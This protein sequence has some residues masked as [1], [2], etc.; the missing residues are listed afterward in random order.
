MTLHL[1][2]TPWQLNPPSAA[3]IGEQAAFAEAHGYQ[4][5]WLP[6]N[7][8]GEGALPDPLMLLASAATATRTIQLATTS[9]LL[10]LRNPLQAAEQVAVLDQLSDGRVLLG[11][12]RGY[13][14]EM[15]RAFHVPVAEK[16]RIFAWTLDLMQKA[17]AGEAISLDGDPEHAVAVHPRPVQQPHPPIWVAAFG[18]KA[19]AQ[20]GRMGLPYLSSPMES[21]QTLA[22]NYAQHR[23]ASLD[24]G[25]QPASEIPLMRTVFVSRDAAE[26]AALRQRMSDEVDNT[27]LQSGETVDDWTLIGDPAFVSDGIARYQETLG[28]THLVVTRLR[29][30]GL[31]DDRLRASLAL[32]A[33]T[34]SLA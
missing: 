4:S 31:P 5:F 34:C 25:V 13:A 17:W 8:F 16:R 19:L 6:E 27:R 1:G 28:M 7:H 24:E 15:L 29:L 30:A 26:V 21:L 33:E 18:P 23:Q 32:L 11:V 12:G 14:P 9:Y 3:S 10:T 2:V 22:D 20:A